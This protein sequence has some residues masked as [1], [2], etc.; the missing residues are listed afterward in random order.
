MHQYLLTTDI[1]KMYYQILK[2]ER[3]TSYKRIIWRGNADKTSTRMS[4]KKWHM[5]KLQLCFWPLDPYISKQQILVHP[6]LLDLK[7]SN[8]T[9]TWT[10][11]LRAQKQNMTCWLFETK[12]WLFL[13]K[14][15]LNCG[16]GLQTTAEGHR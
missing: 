11:Y 14:G 8:R 10:T 12:W 1:A 13:V 4:Y 9:S 2:N 16:S 5:V 15:D 6:I 3:H 7:S